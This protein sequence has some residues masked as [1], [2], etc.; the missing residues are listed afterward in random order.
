M[1]FRLQLTC[2][3]TV[4]ATALTTVPAQ[5]AT[6]ER[7]RNGSFDVDLASWWS[8]KNLVGHRV[9]GELCAT[10]PAGTVNAWDVMIGQ[11]DVPFEAGQPYKLAFT[12][13]ASRNVSIRVVGQLAVAPYTALL[14]GQSPVT[15]ATQ[16]FE[17]TGTPAVDEPKGQVLFQVGGAKEPYELCLDNVSLIGGATPPGG[18]Y[19]GSPVRVNQV[20][21]LPDA[22]K[23]ATIVSEVTEALPWRLLDSAGAEA[24][25]GTTKVYGDDLMSGDHV[26]LADF[27]QVREPGSYRL[28]VDGKRSV[29]FDI[30]PGLYGKLRKD[31]LAYF[32]HNRSGIPIEA[33]HVGAAYARPAGH[34]GVAPNQGDG[35]Q[36]GGWYDAGDHGKYVVNGALAAWELIDSYEQSR[37]VSLSIPESGGELPDILDEA[38]W[39]LDFL[40]R[41]QQDDGMA[42]HKIHDVDG[43]TGMVAPHEDPRERRLFPPSTAAT[44]NLAAVAARCARVYRPFD[45]AYADRCLDAARLAWTAAMKNPAVLAPSTSPAGGGAYGDDV[46]SDEFSWA[47]AELYTATGSSAYLDSIQHTMGP[48]NF[49]WAQTGGLADLALARVKLVPGGE[50]ARYSAARA[51]IVT[52]A[53]KHLDDL[54]SQGYP[55]PDLPGKRRYSWGS[56]SA[57]AQKAM[58]LGF[59]HGI[60]GEAKYRDGV[61]E[62]LDYLLG[63][64]ALNQSYVTGYGERAS[65]NQHHRFWAHQ[66]NAARPHPAPGSMAGGP[67]S[68]VS[69]VAKAPAEQILA[70]CA[71]ATCYIDDIGS[72]ATN[73]VAINWN[74]ALAWVAAFADTAA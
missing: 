43:W 36:R 72:Y 70:G 51:R 62:S 38:K 58:V 32:Y 19:L 13:R 69:E 73:E 63:R 49:S 44:L 11:S 1:S 68:D 34:L 2:V 33:A 60:T 5:A 27:S 4:M 50:N 25:A 35:E 28:E 46:V 42:H 7:L 54:R 8:T 39:E 45:A 41:M 64:N 48:G 23:R 29:P 12:A 3:L 59:A 21:Y 24:A 14:A 15:T 9:N 56:T 16:R 66:A 17:I 57:T 18:R 61:L 37:S 52:A 20:G 53:D 67:N 47:A 65:W 30:A 22:P 55:N 31:S 6:Y 40:L 71:P 26:H 74:S 10:V